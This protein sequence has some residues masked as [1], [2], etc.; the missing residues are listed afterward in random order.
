[1]AHDMLA[2][3]AGYQDELENLE[4]FHGKSDRIAAVQAEI[5]RVC[6]ALAKRVDELV[7]QAEAHE[8]EGRDVLAAQARIEAKRLAAALPADQRPT[9]RPLYADRAPSAPLE[10]AA[11]TTPRETAV[12][13]RAARSTKE[14]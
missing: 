7:D 3:L 8:G 6:A 4:R 1:M 14:K 12:P 9:V 10:T 13:R 5:G 2:E 11:D